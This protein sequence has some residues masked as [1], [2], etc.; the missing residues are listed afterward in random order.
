M[1]TK[2]YKL[3]YEI[4]YK[5]HFIETEYFDTE[6]AGL[7]CRLSTLYTCNFLRYCHILNI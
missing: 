2:K 5:S 1:T 3:Q 6:E 4:A 7:L